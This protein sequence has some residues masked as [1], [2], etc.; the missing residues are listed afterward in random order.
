MPTNIGTPC[1]VSF[2]TIGVP[3][4]NK[5]LQAGGEL[6]VRKLALAEWLIDFARPMVC[7][8]RPNRAM[9]DIRKYRTLERPNIENTAYQGIR[10]PGRQ[11]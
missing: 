11:R 7:S 8:V 10:L 2:E 5:R 1:Y 3:L 4:E 6:I 9:P